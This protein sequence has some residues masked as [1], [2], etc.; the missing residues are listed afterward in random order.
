MVLPALAD[1]S[2]DHSPVDHE[3]GGENHW[4]VKEPPVRVSLQRGISVFLKMTVTYL[5]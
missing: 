2:P 3:K 5:L 4:E 1:H